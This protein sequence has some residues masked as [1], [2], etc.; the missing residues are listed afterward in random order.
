M[1]LEALLDEK[2]E[3]LMSVAIKLEGTHKTLRLLNKSTNKLD[4]LITTGKSFGD[5]KGVGYKCEWYGS[6]TVFVKSGLLTNSFN[7]SYNNPVV[8]SRENKSVVQ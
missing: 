1:Q 7:V 4:H 6:K 8:K 2:D 5:Y 3:N